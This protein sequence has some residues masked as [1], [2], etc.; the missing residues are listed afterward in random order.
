MET[1]TRNDWKEG[2]IDVCDFLRVEMIQFLS[3]ENR[4]FGRVKS[5]MNNIRDA[6][7]RVSKDTTEEKAERYGRILGILRSTIYSEFK[8]L[9]YRRLS[10]ADRIIVIFRK[11][12]E[13]ISDIESDENFKYDREVGTL[14]KVI[15]KLFDNICIRG[16]YDS[17]TKL[18]D[19]IQSS[20]LSGEYGKFSCDV[21]DL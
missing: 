8:R 12:L 18:T 3:D 15:N 20:V 9:G 14:K 19:L 11:I 10:P 6:L 4:Y 16:K 13:I 17:L 21:L 2:L 5:Y 1:L 7:N